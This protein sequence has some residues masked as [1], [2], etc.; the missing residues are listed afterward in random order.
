M[1]ETPEISRALNKV[2]QMC[3][4]HGMSRVEALRQVASESGIDFLVLSAFSGGRNR[5]RKKKAP[6]EA[7]HTHFRPVQ[8]PQ[9]P[10]KEQMDLPFPTPPS[11]Y[12]AC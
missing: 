10:E 3:Q 5:G 9:Q 12:R 4:S 8:A 11:R 2:R 7:H 1:D 6:S